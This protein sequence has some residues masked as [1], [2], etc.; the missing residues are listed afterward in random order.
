MYQS[1]LKKINCLL[2]EA[3]YMDMQ[4]QRYGIT[5]SNPSYK[6]DYLQDLKYLIEYLSDPEGTLESP[7]DPDLIIE[8]VNGSY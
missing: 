5:C 8:K 4:E 6:I 7:C 2:G 1:Q 3:V